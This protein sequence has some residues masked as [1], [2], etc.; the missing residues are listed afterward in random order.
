MVLESMEDLYKN[1]STDE[2]TIREIR[3][4]ALKVKPYQPKAIVRLRRKLKLS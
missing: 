4:M 2:K 3:A 1:G